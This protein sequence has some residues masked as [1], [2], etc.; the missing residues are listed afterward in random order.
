[1]GIW[2]WIAKDFRAFVVKDENL[3]D[4]VVDAEILDEIRETI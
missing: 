2:V 1:M 3:S 4:T